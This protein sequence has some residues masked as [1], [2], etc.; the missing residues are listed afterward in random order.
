M[1]LSEI[2]PNEKN[3]FKVV[4]H[5]PLLDLENLCENVKNSV[6]LS[7]FSHVDFEKLDKEE[8]K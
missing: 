6:D 5:N 2:E 3:Q 8:K 7:R 4:S 1:D